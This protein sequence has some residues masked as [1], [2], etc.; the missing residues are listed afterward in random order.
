[1][2]EIRQ[3]GSEGGDGQGRSLPYQKRQ[4]TIFKRWQAAVKVKRPFEKREDPAMRDIPQSGVQT[5]HSC[6]CKRVESGGWK[7]LSVFGLGIV[8]EGNCVAARRGGEHPEV[9]DR[10]VGNKLDSA[11]CRGEP[12]SE[13]RSPSDDPSHWSGDTRNP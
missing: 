1:M 7:S 12:A 5:P 8:A 3:S 11:C 9:N 6:V 10:S 4:A 2:R 13:W